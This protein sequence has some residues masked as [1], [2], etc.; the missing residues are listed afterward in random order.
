MSS[1]RS[2]SSLS[3]NLTWSLAIVT[4]FVVVITVIVVVVEVA[5]RADTAGA[6]GTASG[7]T[8]V[9][10]E[11]SR[12]LSDAPEGA[13]VL[14]EFLDFE[15]EACGA[16]YPTIE[17]L[18]EQYDGEVKF[19]ARY[20]PIPSHNSAMDAAIAVESAAQQGK[21]EEMYNR[22]YETQQEWG[23]SPTSQKDLF[24]TFAEDLGLDM[25]A[26]DA[27]VADPATQARIQ[28]DQDDGRALGVEG[29]P[30]F[31]LDGEKIQPQSPQEMQDLV[32]AALD[33]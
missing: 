18:R 33:G 9:V 20:F 26:F 8:E 25:A 19:V 32:Q 3:R 2:R 13:P 7:S 22:M 4:V 21:L 17:A 27:A 16:W 12:V 30:T 23:E 31:F 5:G 10:R 28:S 29:T 15:C 24:R 14:V 6:G 11:D 1:V